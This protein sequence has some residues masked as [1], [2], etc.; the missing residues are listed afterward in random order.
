MAS[1]AR[2][3][4]IGGSTPINKSR[5]RRPQI[6]RGG[7]GGA[8]LYVMS[9]ETDRALTCALSSEQIKDQSFPSQ[10][11]AIPVSKC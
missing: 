11:D 10:A 3:Q 9:G 5:R 4:I 1:A 2:R 7:G 6:D 8:W